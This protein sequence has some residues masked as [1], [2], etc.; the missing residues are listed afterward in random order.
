MN[1]FLTLLALKIDSILFDVGITVMQDGPWD[2]HTNKKVEASAAADFERARIA[3]DMA[4][5]GITG[6]FHEHYGDIIISTEKTI[7]FV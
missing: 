6:A 7:F 2:A 5:G 1:E 3:L 4:R